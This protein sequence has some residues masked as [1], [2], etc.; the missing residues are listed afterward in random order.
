MANKSKQKGTAWETAVV[1]YLRDHGWNLVERRALSGSQ[2]KGDIANLATPR[3]QVVVECKAEKAFD[4]ARYLREVRTETENASAWVGVAWVKAPRKSV[5][6]SYI[7]MDP[8]TFLEL[9][10]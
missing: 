1:K 5:E 3:G 6:D 7:L 8:A 2:D 4:L 10:G 9:I